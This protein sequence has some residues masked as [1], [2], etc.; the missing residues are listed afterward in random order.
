MGIAGLL[1]FRDEDKH[2]D[3]KDSEPVGDQDED[4]ASKDNEPANDQD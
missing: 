4:E 1:I 2:E 3:D